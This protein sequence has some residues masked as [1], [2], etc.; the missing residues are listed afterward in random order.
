MHA[1]KGKALKQRL[2]DLKKSG[3]T[4]VTEWAL[5]EYLKKESRVTIAQWKAGKNWPSRIEE[6]EMERFLELAGGFFALIASGMSYAEALR[7][8]GTP[9]LQERK[10]SMC[11][12]PGLVQEHVEGGNFRVA[13]KFDR[14]EGGKEKGGKEVHLVSSPLEIDPQ[15]RERIARAMGEQI[16]KLTRNFADEMWK[17][18]NSALGEKPPEEKKPKK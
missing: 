6:T 9:A 5:A 12:Y 3:R 4:D 10:E 8:S 1:L 13:E 14:V 11:T 16:E 7:V 17:S 15:V 18:V 2:R